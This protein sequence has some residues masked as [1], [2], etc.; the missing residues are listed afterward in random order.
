MIPPEQNAEFV[1]CMEDVLGRYHQPRDPGGR[2]F[3][4][5]NSR[6]SDPGDPSSFAGPAGQTRAGGLRV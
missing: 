4:W 6:S 3:V 1:A 2:W 5:M